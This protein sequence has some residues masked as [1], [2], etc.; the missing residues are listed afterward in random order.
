MGNHT[1]LRSTQHLPSGYVGF[2]TWWAPV[3]LHCFLLL[4]DIEVKLRICQNED[5]VS[6]QGSLWEIWIQTGPSLREQKFEHAGCLLGSALGYASWFFEIKPW[7]LLKQEKEIPSS[8][9]EREN[10]SFPPSTCRGRSDSV[11]DK[12]TLQ[13]PRPFSRGLCLWTHHCSPI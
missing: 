13:I 1:S 12:K 9:W 10:C 5:T 7:K 3:L 11:L 8:V 6:R 4:V 2:P